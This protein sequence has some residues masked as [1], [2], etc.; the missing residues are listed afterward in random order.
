AID[1]R[2]AGSLKQIDA[3]TSSMSSLVGE[4]LDISRSQ[5]LRHLELDRERF[6]L[7]AM[8]RE[9][10]AEHQATSPEHR[11]K[12]TASCK[13]APGNWDKVRLKR[14]LANLLG[15]AI[16]F[17]RNGGVV[18]IGVTTEEASTVVAVSDH[19]IGI[20]EAELSKIFERFYRASNV[21]GVVRGTGLGLGYAKQVVESHGG[22]LA[23]DSREGQGTTVTIRLPNEQASEQERGSAS[24]HTSGA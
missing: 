20:P 3:A 17:S 13:E 18:S 12:L 2:I 24:P 6:D 21:V 15:N 5:M 1:R 19:G 8:A 4:F 23:I 10:V 9:V 11:L 22:E 7:V 14:A 16:K